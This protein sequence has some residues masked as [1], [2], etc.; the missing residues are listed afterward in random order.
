MARILVADDDE[1]GR[2]MLAEALLDAG[3]EVLEARNGREAL[4]VQNVQNA[5]LLLT[6]L[7]MPEQE[8]LETIREFRKRYPRLPIIAMSGGGYIEPGGYLQMAARVGA[9]HTLIKPFSSVDLIRLIDSLVGSRG[10]SDA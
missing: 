6:D 10:G 3:H 5:D 9:N 4:E 1:A 8:G 7:L 2:L